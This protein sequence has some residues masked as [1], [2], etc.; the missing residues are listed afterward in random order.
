MQTYR[1]SPRYNFH[2]QR[3]VPVLPAHS[4]LSAYGTDHEQRRRLRIAGRHDR[5][6]QFSHTTIQKAFHFAVKHVAIFQSKIR[7]EKD[8]INSSFS[9]N[10]SLLRSSGSALI[11]SGLILCGVDGDKGITVPPSLCVATTYSH[12]GSTKICLPPLSVRPAK[13]P[14]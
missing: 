14:P 13:R 5:C 12:S 10:G 9:F 4:G 11:S 7:P 8:M 6:I 2:A 1:K 3:Q